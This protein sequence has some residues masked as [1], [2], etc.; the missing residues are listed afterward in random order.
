LGIFRAV[1]SD[2]RQPLLTID[3]RMLRS[4]GIGTY[5]RA[6]APRV[7]ERLPEARICLLG[8]PEELAR[9]RWTGAPRV[10]IRALS[11]GIYAA[12]EQPRL[13]AT[14]PADTRVFWSPHVNV[15]IAGPGRLFAAV[16]DV[17]Y[18]NPPREARP[19]FDKW[20]YLKLVMRGLRR[21]AKTVVCSSDFT[22]RELLRLVGPFSC[23]VHTVHL[24]VERDLFTAPP[25]PRPH[26]RPYLLYLGNLKPH[27][28]LTRL[29]AAFS[30]ILERVPHDLVLVGGG[31]PE[32]FRRELG[33]AASGRVHFVGSPDGP[34]TR[35]Y[36]AHAAG[37]VLVSLYEGFGLPPLEAMALG[38]PVLVSG[39]ASLP[40]VC[41][42]AALYAD[43]R[44]VQD[45][46]GG[47][48]RL[49]TDEVERDRLRRRGPERAS[50][51]DWE[52]TA[53][54]T[55]ELLRALF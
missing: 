32:P 42:D 39:E 37:L 7:I 3:A 34:R 48:V 47:L 5:L 44:S 2:A 50:E 23:P 30:S 46:A 9:E 22:R 45:I 12:L 27:K 43:A 6:V 38:V 24:G 35:T 8:N 20:L 51:F 25:L 21:R 10:E 31:D 41:G 36:V 14:T 54:R 11:A 4:S 18:A 29:L 53:E 17:F 13:L 40:E 28:N 16:H 15:P 49:V 33:P 19:R 1:R 26:P 52:R 55:A